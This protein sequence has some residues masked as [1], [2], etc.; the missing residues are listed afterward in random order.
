LITKKPQHSCDKESQVTTKHECM[1]HASSLFA[2]H[3]SLC[4]LELERLAFHHKETTAF[5][6]DWERRLGAT[7]HEKSALSVS[8][9]R[10]TTLVVT[11]ACRYRSFYTG[12]VY[13]GIIM[14]V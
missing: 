6:L 1:L 9:L 13:T 14:P 11:K 4:S 12:I 3:F 10:T 2:F 7:N 8:M 5:L